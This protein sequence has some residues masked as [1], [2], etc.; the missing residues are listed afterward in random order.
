MRQALFQVGQT[1]SPHNTAVRGM[2]AIYRSS[3]LKRSKSGFPASLAERLLE[4]VVVEERP[5]RLVM[6]GEPQ[7]GI[8]TVLYSCMWRPSC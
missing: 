6:G 8:R 5:G 1:R 4:E 2:S 7:K 3:P